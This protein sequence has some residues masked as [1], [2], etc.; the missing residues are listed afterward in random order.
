MYDTYQELLDMKGVKSSDVS[1][2]T[3]I[4]N[5]T[6]SDWKNGKYTPKQDKLQK[7]ADYFGVSIEYLM[8]GKERESQFTDENA[9][10][11]A[12]IRRESKTNKVIGELMDLPYEKRENILDVLEMLIN[13]EK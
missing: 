7:V 10:L 12:K 13:N 11:V 1:R 3:G 4:S 9:H 8:T 5:M 2:A 6:L